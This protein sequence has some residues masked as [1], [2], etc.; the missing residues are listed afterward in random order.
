MIIPEVTYRNLVL[1]GSMGSILQAQA[2]AGSKHKAYRVSW[3]ANCMEGAGLATAQL[4]K[5]PCVE[6]A[7]LTKAKVSIM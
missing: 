6:P 7:R 5:P 4:Q 2:G 3:P 1:Q